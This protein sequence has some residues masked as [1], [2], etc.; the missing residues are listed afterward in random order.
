MEQILHEWTDRS[1]LYLYITEN[2]SKN[3]LAR[4]GLF[5]LGYFLRKNMKR[6]FII[7]LFFFV[8]LAATSSAD[9][10]LNILFISVDDMND[11]AGL[12]KGY[13]GKVHVPNLKR[14][15]SLEMTL[16]SFPLDSTPLGQLQFI[17]VPNSFPLFSQLGIYL[18]VPIP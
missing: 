3:R 6:P 18:N 1:N 11:W 17:H 16:S 2:I 10:R 7:I 15:G 9:E 14:L 12:S 5:Y 4:R 13:P 8:L